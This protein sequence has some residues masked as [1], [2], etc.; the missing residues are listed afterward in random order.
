MYKISLASS[1]WQIYCQGVHQELQ[2]YL[3]S[4][5]LLF[6]HGVEGDLPYVTTDYSFE[7]KGAGKIHIYKGLTR[8]GL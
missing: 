4:L 2:L 7:A 5:F 3:T 8:P 1:Q 6:Q